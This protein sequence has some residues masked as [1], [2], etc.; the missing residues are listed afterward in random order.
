VKRAL[1][2]V[3]CLAGVAHAEIAERSRVEVKPP[4]KPYKQV[5]VDNALG[6]VRIEGY[7]G[8]AI[9]IETNKR[10]PDEEALERLRVSLIPD[11]DGTVRITTAADP[12]PESKPLPRSAVSI[13]VVI[14]APRNVR[15]DATVGSGKLEVRNMDAGGELDSA[16]GAITVESVNGDLYTHSVSGRM[17]ISNAFGPVDAATISSDVDLDSISGQKLVASAND[18]KITGRRVRARD[19][20][21]TTIRGAIS[22]EAEAVARGHI[23]VSSLRGDVDVRVRRQAQ[24]AMVVRGRGTKVDLGS[25][26]VS[27]VGKWQEAKFGTGGETTIVEL[28]ATRGILRFALIQ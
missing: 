23:V 25:Q 22:L 18:G 17:S 9:I 11:P 1:L 24:N 15:I 6:N 28:R 5:T 10:A 4:G 21:L 26:Q 12:L 14:R 16:S 8:N 27:L 7:D 19:V 20:E 13:D 3:C 2:L